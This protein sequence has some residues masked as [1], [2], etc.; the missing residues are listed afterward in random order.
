M[1]YIAPEPPA[2]DHGLTLT[3]ITHFM[4]AASP[5]SGIGSSPGISHSAPRCGTSGSVKSLR[6]SQRIR[7]LDRYSLTTGASATTAVIIQ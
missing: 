4:R 2:I 1:K 7:S 3:I 5:S 6:K